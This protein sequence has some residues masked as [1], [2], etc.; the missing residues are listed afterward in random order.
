MLKSI[1]SFSL[2]YYICII[3]FSHLVDSGG[4]D[5]ETKNNNSNNRPSITKK[6]NNNKDK[7]NPLTNSASSSASRTKQ[8]TSR[9][10]TDRSKL[11]YQRNT[12]RQRSVPS[13]SS[14][15]DQ[16]SR[17]T[18]EP[19]RNRTIPSSTFFPDGIHNQ[20]IT[21]YQVWQW[22]EE[23]R[24]ALFHAYGAYMKYS[25]P[26]DELKP[27]S[28]KPR[29][30]NER[31]RGN[32]DDSLGGFALTLI[33]SLDTLAMMGELPMFRCAISRIIHDV[34]VDR[35][36]TVSLFETNIR[37]LGGLLSAHLLS[38]DKKLGIWDHA[39]IINKETNTR[40][41]SQAC[42]Y[43]LSTSSSFSKHPSYSYQ[44]HPL[45]DI[46]RKSVV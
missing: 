30:Y 43:N 19:R 13:S 44:S 24:E 1:V 21:P 36:H 26:Y 4:N 27:L 17:T 42:R 7:D 34:Q 35:N 38:V 31:D 18:S 16:Y 23:T 12:H 6:S 40:D 11:N 41:C 15:S 28:C 25:Y 8:P 2:L 33:D 5:Y 45:Y 46:D 3:G 20:G 10:F 22:R 29:K 32:L 9:L 39:C 37:I 14:S